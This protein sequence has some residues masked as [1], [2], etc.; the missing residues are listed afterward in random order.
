[1]DWA[2][3]A[4]AVKPHV[5]KIETPQGHGTGF[6]AFYNDDRRL[7]A[8]ATADHVISYADEWHL[9]IR[10]KNENSN[11]FL[12][13]GNRAVFRNPA[14]DTA[15]L[16]FLKGSLQVPDTPKALLPLDELCEIGTDVGWLGFPSI[17]PDVNCFFSGKIS[18]SGNSNYLIDGVAINGVSGGPVFHGSEVTGIRIIG[19]V[20]AYHPNFSS[21]SVL[22]GLLR[23]QSVAH[24]HSVAHNVRTMDEAHRKRQE[25]ERAQ[26]MGG[27]FGP[28]T[29]SA[30]DDSVP[31]Q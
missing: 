24:F 9:P 4:R 21:G 6:L 2:D 30:F 12:D 23:A 14:S 7:C 5:V 26:K 28:G 27:L 8:I 1:M 18:A 17:A 10:I 29:T 16:L 15:V 13:A 11:V 22:P 25:Y 3:A 19:C 20:S 31:P